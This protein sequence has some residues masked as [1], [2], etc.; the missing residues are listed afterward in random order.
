YT[1]SRIRC[2]HLRL[3]PLKSREETGVDDSEGW[4][5]VLEFPCDITRESE[6]R[7]LVYR[8]GHD[9]WDIRKSTEDVRER[10]QRRT[11]ARRGC[12]NG[13]EMDFADVVPV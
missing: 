6:V 11:R 5:E 4:F 13:T 1:R 3:R 2:A 10:S 9:A 12:L 8:A 7:V